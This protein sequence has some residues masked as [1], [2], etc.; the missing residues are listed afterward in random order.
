MMAIVYCG[1]HLPLDRTHER[2]L[3]RMLPLHALAKSASARYEDIVA[4]A[5]DLC[6]HLLR[7]R[8][9]ASAEE[10]QIPS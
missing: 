3:T 4:Y 6:L 9:K 1:S 2:H 8:S 10:M 7:Y 5:F